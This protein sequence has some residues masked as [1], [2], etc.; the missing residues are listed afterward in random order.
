MAES[1][2]PKQASGPEFVR[3]RILAR[4]KIAAG[5]TP[6]PAVD[7]RVDRW[8]QRA[9]RIAVNKAFEPTGR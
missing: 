5:D 7:N 2:T 1:Q 9:H 4:Q 6:E 3:K 8:M